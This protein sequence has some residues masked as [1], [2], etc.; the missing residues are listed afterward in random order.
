MSALK[1]LWQACQTHAQ[2]HRHAY[3][4]AHN[5]SH[6]AYLGLV[7]IHGPYHIAALVMLF[8]LTA[9]LLFKLEEL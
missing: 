7:S 8:V 1:A 9:G 4:R 3:H 5:Y 2:A 6:L